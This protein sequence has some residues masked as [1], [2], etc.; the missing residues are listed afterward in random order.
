MGVPSANGHRDVKL[1]VLLVY[2]AINRRVVCGTVGPIEPCVEQDVPQYDVKRTRFNLELCRVEAHVLHHV[3]GQEVSPHGDGHS[4]P[5]TNMQ[6]CLVDQR[7][8]RL[9]PFLYF[10]HFNLVFWQDKEHNQPVYP[11]KQEVGR[12]RQRP[13]DVRVL[14]FKP[15]KAIHSNDSIQQQQREITLN[16][17]S[18]YTNQFCC[19][20][21]KPLV[22]IYV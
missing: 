13:K 14:V 2:K 16:N 7:L 19:F 18:L 15:V 8:V 9:L 11:V 1:V 20:H 6:Q 22:Y 10:L 4:M 5:K 17:Y 12:Q 21:F 3:Q